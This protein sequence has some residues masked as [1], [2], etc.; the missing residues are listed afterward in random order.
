MPNHQKIKKHPALLHADDIKAICKPLLHLSKIDYFS[1]VKVN[2]KGFSGLATNPQFVEHYLTQGYFNCDSH[3]QMLESNIE[4]IVQDSITHFGQTKQLFRDCQAFNVHHIFTLLHR[5][6]DGVNAY[7]FATSDPNN[8]LNEI[9]LKNIPFLKNFISYFNEALKNDKSLNLAYNVKFKLDQSAQY[10]SG[11]DYIR[12]QINIDS[13]LKDIRAKRLHVMNSN[14]SYITKRELECLLCLHLGN[15]AETIAKT[16]K[17]TE[18]TVRAHINSLKQK[19]NCK[20]LFQLGEK[21]A[22]HNITQLLE[23]AAVRR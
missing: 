6:Q 9:Y 17:I 11:I 8:H 23:T 18:R 16:L 4:F 13:L 12:D 7:H 20:T 15:T 5:E 19:L 3:L 10:E 1:H 2:S 21:V 14:Q 22:T